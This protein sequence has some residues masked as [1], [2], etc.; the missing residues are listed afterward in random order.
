MRNLQIIKH[1]LVRTY[2]IYCLQT[3]GTFKL[4]ALILDV[5]H[6][7]QSQYFIFKMGIFLETEEASEVCPLEKRTLIISLILFN[8]HHANMKTSSGRTN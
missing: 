4:M 1:S 5:N 7:Q 2:M 8:R 6:F 3:P